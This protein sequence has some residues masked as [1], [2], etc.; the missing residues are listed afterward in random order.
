[1]GLVTFLATRASRW[2]PD[3]LALVGLAAL[4]ASASLAVWPVQDVPLV[5]DWTY[6]WSVEHLQ[7]TGRLALL[8]WSVH[9]PIAQILWAWPFVAL[10]GFS[11]VVLRLT[12]LVLGWVAALALFALL[13]VSGTSPL[14]ALVGTLALLF[15]PAFFFLEHSFMTDVP[16]LAAMNLALL[17]YALWFS[18]RRMRWLVLGGAWAIAAFLVRQLGA[19]L[20]LVPLVHLALAGRTFGRQPAVLI[21]TAAP[22]PIVLAL[23]WGLRASLGVPT[24]YAQLSSEAAARVSPAWWLGSPAWGEAG[25]LIA[26]VLVSV[27]L[28]LAPL[29]LVVLTARRRGAVGW[30][31]VGAGVVAV[32]LAAAG[33]LPDPLHPGQF[34][35]A[36]ELGL[37]HLLITSAERPWPLSTAATALV[38]VGAFV[39]G[40]VAVTAT[41][42]AG[43]EAVGTMLV[44][45]SLGHL[46]AGAVAA[47]IHDR[48]YLPL[49]PALLFGLVRL[50]PGLTATA[51]AGALVTATLGTVAV[52]GTLDGLRL[53]E[54]LAR[55]RAELVA[56][57][58]PPP[59]IDA[60]YTLN[61]WWL[62]AQGL[63]DRD[64][65][66]LVTV[67]RALPWV[68]AASPLPG[69]VVERVVPVAVVWSRPGRLHV[70]RRAPEGMRGPGLATR[71]RPAAA[72]ARPPPGIP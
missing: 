23:W 24:K 11:F 40:V 31:A 5:D 56:R 59:D 68:L 14:A 54:A 51:V 8:P 30:A 28:V 44:T 64:E 57:G 26:H 6:A 29:T 55:E 41:A 67:R 45:A 72:I 2:R 10:G 27:G 34:L 19:V 12:T 66:Q 38:S 62:Y 47:L 4:A 32:A 60:G 70:L 39:S 21:A 71:T 16:Y 49:L 22:L 65:V 50:L 43:R 37:G 35:S 63:V 36:T 18:R 13:R 33:R 17:C 58:V 69:Y 1:V 9:Y 48:Y 53:N 7:R 15:N 52:T 25:T 61:G 42:L 20:L 3:V 46:A